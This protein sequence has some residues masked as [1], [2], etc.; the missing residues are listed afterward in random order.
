MQSVG[1]NDMSFH[2]CD[3]AHPQHTNT[4][5]IGI[6]S[7]TD[8]YDGS[9]KLGACASGKGVSTG[10]DISWKWEV[11][12]RLAN[13]HDLAQMGATKWTCSELVRARVQDWVSRHA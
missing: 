13:P 9:E 1:N 7:G 10:E 3:S 8:H 6:K 4:I 11:P 5:T 2:R 12:D